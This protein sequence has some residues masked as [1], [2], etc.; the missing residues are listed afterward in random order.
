MSSHIIHNMK[1]IGTAGKQEKIH[2]NLNHKQNLVQ[3]GL[4]DKIISGNSMDNSIIVEVITLAL[5]T[6]IIIIILLF[7]ILIYIRSVDFQ[8]LAINTHIFSGKKFNSFARNA[9][10][11]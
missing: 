2:L 5:V 1:I 3:K 8:Y 6:I 11:S 10:Q 7:R 4:E 9:F